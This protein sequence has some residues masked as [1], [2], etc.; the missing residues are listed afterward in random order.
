MGRYVHMDR[1]PVFGQSESASSARD[2]FPVRVIRQV[3]WNIVG[4][5]APMIRSKFKYGGWGRGLLGLVRGTRR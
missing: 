4:P 1:E 5:P 2:S 3:L